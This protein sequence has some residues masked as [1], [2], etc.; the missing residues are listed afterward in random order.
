MVGRLLLF[1]KG[2]QLSLFGE[3]RQPVK[4]PGSRGGHFRITPKGEV[5]YDTAPPPEAPAPPPPPPP[6]PPPAAPPA[7]P[8]E[9]AD[10]RKVLAKLA[11]GQLYAEGRGDLKQLLRATRALYGRSPDFDAAWDAAEELVNAPRPDREPAFWQLAEQAS[12]ALDLPPV[13]ERIEPPR[14]EFLIPDYRLSRLQDQVD[15]LNAR[16]KRMKLSPEVWKPITV[17]VHGEEFHDIRDEH[18][19]P[20]GRKRRMLH[21]RVEGETPRYA[22]WEFAATVQH[23]IDEQTDKPVNV[24]RVAGGSRAIP[25]EYRSV[26]PSCDH[27]HV[28]R[29]R[30]DTFVLWHPEK[31]WKHV[32]RQCLR[33]FLGHESPEGLA[34]AA[35]LLAELRDYT[36]GDAEDEEERDREG[37]GGGHDYMDA[38]QFLATAL[39]VLREEGWKPRAFEEKSTASRVLQALYPGKNEQPWV[40][41]T[42]ADVAEAKRAFEWLAGRGEHEDKPF[43]KDLDALSDFEWNVTAT[44]RPGA[45]KPFR[46][47]GIAAAGAMAWQRE[48]GRLAEAKRKAERGGGKHIGEV[49]KR[50]DFVLTLTGVINMGEGQYGER[51]L[52]KFVDQDGNE[53]AWWTGDNPT[54]EVFTPEAYTLDGKSVQEV[55][56]TTRFYRADGTEVKADKVRWSH[57]RQGYAE[58]D[59]QWQPLPGELTSKRDP[60]HWEVT[61]G[62]GKKKETRRYDSEEAVKADPAVTVIPERRGPRWGVGE[63]FHAR[64][65]VKKHD[66][67]RGTPQTTLTRVEQVKPFAKSTL[68][69]FLTRGA[70]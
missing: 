50:G 66:V 68:L 63:T 28:N 52:V 49:G 30:L 70:A 17:E 64:A 58:Y 10:A 32:G 22:G 20:T 1:L 59:E 37:G 7:P 3:P 11:E 60:A 16:A 8:P 48:Q 40:K 41:P 34:A 47:A 56:P 29:R 39:A 13:E 25:K 62:K 54:A 24:L 61:V 57:E 65:T 5:R 42:A 18:D 51:F 38:E 55:G 36:W 4:A 53:A 19:A 2:A 15:K 45:L 9:D 31:G 69:L 23:G 67:F 33:D 44:L 27:C 35:E 12:K 43:G 6:P 26:G 14:T 21:V 46:N